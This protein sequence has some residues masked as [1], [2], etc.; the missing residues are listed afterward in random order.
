M[1][2]QMTINTLPD[3]ALLEIFDFYEDCSD[4][5]SMCCFKRPCTVKKW[6]PLLDVCRRWRYIIFES[7]QR[8]HLRL[9]CNETTPTK[10]LLDIWPPFP[11]TVTL[12]ARH[13]DAKGEGNIITAL[14]RRSHVTT[15]S[16]VLRNS[17]MG[18][19]STVMRYPFP[20]LTKLYLSSESGSS[21]AVVLPEAFL[22]GSAPCLERIILWEIAY[23]ALPKLVSS[24]T[25]LVYLDLYHIPHN[26]SP[27]EMANCLAA[28]PSLQI[29]FIR[30]QSPH[31]HPHHGN[32]LPLT[33]RI[34]PSLTS[35]EFDGVNKYLEE[36]VSRIN[37][38]LLNRLDIA[39]HTDIIIDIPQLYDFIVRSEKIKVSAYIHAK[40]FLSPSSV[41]IDLPSV[42]LKSECDTF[43]QGFSWTVQLC[44][45]L[46]PLLRHMAWLK[47]RGSNLFH[48][49]AE[50][51]EDRASALCLQLLSLFTAV[52]D[53]DV[54]KEMGPLVTHALRELT[55]ERAT[56]VLPALKHL[57]LG[58]GTGPFS[59]PETQEALKPFIAARRLDVLLYSNSQDLEVNGR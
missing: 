42:T 28:P 36:L 48:P 56:E 40:V 8:L 39:F 32:P 34:L 16:I 21:A 54:S 57:Q 41:F 37:A 50:L 6:K 2:R 55:G 12:H 58:L 11:I 13:L 5:Y 24:A 31:S 25:R 33:R 51:L 26:I 10:E 20:L 23:P 47:I 22:S 35:F 18:R 27:E 9:G 52:W 15:L 4:S 30:F 44:N 7:P 1:F 17:F 38:P 43:Y 19:F 49:E 14:E 45:Q 29:A 46:S 3:D 59:E 53:L